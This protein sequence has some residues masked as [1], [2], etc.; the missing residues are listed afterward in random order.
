MMILLKKL[1]QKNQINKKMMM[2]IILINLSKYILNNLFII[3]I[4]SI[5]NIN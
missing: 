5:C 3:S 1:N 4:I 2:I